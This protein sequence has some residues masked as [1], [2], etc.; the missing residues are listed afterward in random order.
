M[1]VKPLPLIT[2]I[3]GASLSGSV[4]AKEITAWVIDAEIERPFFVQLEEQFNQ[5]YAGDDVSVKIKP[6]PGYND[7]IQAAWMS[8]DMPDIIMIDGPNMA[9]YVWSG[10]LKPIDQLVS[11]ETIDQI[12]P[13]LIA[14]GTYSPTKRIY[15]LAAGDSSVALWAN[16]KY[17]EQAGVSIPTT[18]DEA[19]TYE[20]FT[21]VLEKLS[22]VEGVKWPLDMKLNYEG[23]WN[24]YGFY[25]WVKSG[26]GDIINQNSWTADGTINSKESVDTLTK[27]QDWVKKGYIVPPT[28]GDNRFYG[29]KSA[30]MSWVGNW[31]WRPHSESLGDDLVLIPA[32]KF[33]EKTY[34][35]NGSWGWAV[36]STTDNDKEIATFLNFA[37]S[38]E[39]VAKWSQFTGYIPARKD[40]LPLAPM[41]AENG[42]MRILAEQAQTIALVRPVHPAYPVI[43]GEFG[44]AVK[45]ILDGADVEKSLDRAARV[46]DN[47]IED[48]MNYPPFNK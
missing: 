2:A 3:I 30:A 11:Q 37:L 5:A 42:P 15:M 8:Q 14:Q 23:E 36:P 46:I 45:N 27:V 38:K 6:I 22:K 10:M 16:K 41:Y 44:K 29:D 19:W 12:L 9:N 33:G 21:S 35:P 13:G 34:S 39:Q 43:S 25:P 32:P 40:A 28:A 18:L 26:G 20:E 7:A 17:L 47:D 31:M 48:N 24:T 4:F 1:N